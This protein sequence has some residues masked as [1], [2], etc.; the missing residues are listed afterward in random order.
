MQ[1]SKFQYKY[2]VRRLKRANNKL[3]NDKFVQGL[4]KGGGDIFKE[5]KKH[6]GKVATT[7]S[8]INDHVGSHNIANNFAEIYSKL[9][10]QHQHGTD[11]I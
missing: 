11:I 2:A 4:L 6:R 7:S 3:Q 10:N 1:Y 5:I 9:Y 8:R